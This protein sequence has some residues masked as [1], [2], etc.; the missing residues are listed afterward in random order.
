MASGGTGRTGR[1]GMMEL[2][3]YN[4]EY[5]NAKVSVAAMWQQIEDLE[6]VAHDPAQVKAWAERVHDE[7]QKC[8][9]C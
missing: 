2:N 9:A 4:P 1:R 3:D 6:A 8:E 7:L 5:V